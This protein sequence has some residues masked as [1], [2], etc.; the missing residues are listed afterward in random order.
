MISIL[1]KRHFTKN[2]L[3]MFLL[4]LCQFTSLL[5]VIFVFSLNIA[6]DDYN[7]I[8][9][10]DSHAITLYCDRLDTNQLESIFEEGIYENISLFV[11]DERGV[12]VRQILCSREIPPLYLS[13]GRYFTEIEV[14]ERNATAVILD[15]LRINNEILKPGDAITI[16]GKEYDIV[17]CL[18]VMPEGTVAEMPFVEGTYEEATV[19]FFL[20]KSISLVDFP[21]YANHLQTLLAARDVEYP[22]EQ[23]IETTDIYSSI[24]SL[25]VFIIANINFVA[26]YLYILMRER[27]TVAIF[28]MN[29]C[30]ERRCNY[31]LFGEFLLLSLPTFV[32]ASLTYH[33]AL[34]WVL[35][36]MNKD[37]VYSMG[38][39]D[40]GLVLVMYLLGLL[41]VFVPVILHYNRKNPVA[42]HRNT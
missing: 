42:L 23:I 5:A 15:G 29:G 33:Y 22:T 10:E 18:T 39:L 25:P 17:G 26:L 11:A 7:K 34:N 14:A 6:R 20:R 32:L 35:P 28:R 37:V 36:Y 24:V 1:I 19:K 4:F 30:S 9:D 13:V 27:K 21:L 16:M 8:F 40:Y 38:L 2:K 31:L 41:L 3:A 12:P